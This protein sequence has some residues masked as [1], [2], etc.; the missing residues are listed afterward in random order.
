MVTITIII[1]VGINAPTLYQVNETSNQKVNS[2]SFME[3]CTKLEEIIESVVRQR[4]NQEMVSMNYQ[5]NHL[6]LRV[7]EMEKSITVTAMMMEE[8]EL[9]VI[10]SVA[11]IIPVVV[12]IIQF[13]LLF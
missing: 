4:K 8:V 12:M 13:S 1:T 10:G 2:G 6:I 7:K 3:N 9:L 11:V 5:M